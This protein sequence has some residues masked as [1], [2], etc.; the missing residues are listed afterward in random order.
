MTLKYATYHG[1]PLPELRLGSDDDERDP[2]Q[3]GKIY[4]V[5]EEAMAHLR[6]VL[7]SQPKTKRRQRDKTNVL[8]NLLRRQ[9]EK[10][11]E[12]DAKKKGGG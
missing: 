7:A 10:E 4:P 1:P 12:R 9:R 5:S 11:R 6:Q 2:P 3:P 8:G